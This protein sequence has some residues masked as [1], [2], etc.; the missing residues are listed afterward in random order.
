MESEDIEESGKS[1]FED[2]YSNRR[3]QRELVDLIQN[4]D[5]T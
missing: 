2:K 3:K 4:N 5:V 1:D